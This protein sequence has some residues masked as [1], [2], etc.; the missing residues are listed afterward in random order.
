MN[1]K[2]ILSIL[3]LLCLFVLASC[4]KPGNEAIDTQSKEVDTQT[5]P[6]SEE[7]DNQNKVDEFKTLLSKQDLSP[8]YERMF[9][10]TFKQDYVSY[11]NSYGEEE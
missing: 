1:M 4:N 6:P 5:D 8:F 3:L 2:K 7:I 10:S 9:S 11:T